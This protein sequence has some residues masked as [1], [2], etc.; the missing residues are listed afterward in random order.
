[1]VGAREKKKRKKNGW[2]V[3]FLF[4][5]KADHRRGG[6]SHN[7]GAQLS[8]GAVVARNG[9]CM[10]VMVCNGGGDQAV[11]FVTQGITGEGRCYRLVIL[12]GWI[13]IQLGL[14]SWPTQPWTHTELCG[15]QAGLRGGQ[16]WLVHA[17]DKLKGTVVP[18][19]VIRLH[20]RSNGMRG[21]ASERQRRAIRSG[22]M[23]R[24]AGSRPLFPDQSQEKP[25]M[26][27]GSS[28]VPGTPFSFG[29]GLRR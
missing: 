5:R 7:H 19:R 18:W 10:L 15:K 3:S 11:I 29:I 2:R 26:R 22:E 12:T 1:M 6:S 9:D 23:F 25:E 16:C 8:G 4:Y 21:E 27:P 28:C 20:R 14:A 13:L 17:E 24:P